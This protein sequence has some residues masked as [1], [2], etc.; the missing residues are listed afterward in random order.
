[1][2]KTVHFTQRYSN[3]FLLIFGI[4]AFVLTIV[5]LVLGL[6]VP[7]GLLTTQAHDDALLFQYADNLLSF[8]WLG[9]YNSKTLVKIEVVFLFVLWKQKQP[10][11]PEVERWL[12]VT[13]FALSA[14]VLIFGVEFFCGWLDEKVYISFYA[15]GAYVLLMLVKY[16]S[17]YLGVQ[18]IWKICKQNRES[19]R[20]LQKKKQNA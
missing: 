17:I 18:S 2:E 12:I 5:R 10:V 6:I 19:S 9:D 4:V 13:G 3:N 14:F 16:L 1:M 8:N 20:K 7:V 15:C 11:W